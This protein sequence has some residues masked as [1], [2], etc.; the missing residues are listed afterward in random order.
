MPAIANVWNV[1]GVHQWHQWFWFIIWKHVVIHIMMFSIIIYECLKYLPLDCLEHQCRR[2]D[3]NRRR[4]CARCRHG[5]HDFRMSSTVLMHRRTASGHTELRTLFLHCCC[6]N[7]HHL[8]HKDKMTN[9]F[10]TNT[11]GMYYPSSYIRLWVLGSYQE[12]CTQDWWSW[13]MVSIGAEQF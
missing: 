4:H 5:W 13:S 8:K 12:R 1:N 9:L 7:K 11:Y 10:I 2:T 3:M 6:T